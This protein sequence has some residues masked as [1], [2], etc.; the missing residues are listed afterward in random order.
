MPKQTTSFI[1]GKMN[2][3]LDP[4]IIPVGEYLDAENIM[5][6]QSE[7]SDVGSVEALKDNLKLTSGTVA[8]E[9]Y[10]Y[11]IGYC[12]DSENDK[13]YYFVTKFNSQGGSAKPESSDKSAIIQ[14]NFFNNSTTI[15]IESKYLNFDKFFP[16]TGCNV[17]NDYLYFTDNRN[18]PRVFNVNDAGSYSTSSILEDQLSVAKYAPFCAPKLLQ[19][20][21]VLLV[22]GAVGA[23]AIVNGAVNNSANVAVDGNI[24]GTTIAVGMRVTGTGITGTVTVNT[25]TSQSAIVLSTAV[26][27]ADNT[28]LTFA[29]T[30]VTIT[31]ANAALQTEIGNGVKFKVLDGDKISFQDVSHIGTPGQ[32]PP[33]PFETNTQ[34]F[35]DDIA[36]SSLSGTTLTLNK[37]VTISDGT[38][39]TLLCCSMVDNSANDSAIDTE[40]LKEKFVK[41]SYRFKFKDNTYSLMA[42][43]SQTAFIP[44]IDTFTAQLQEDAYEQAEVLTF[45]NSINQLELK[46]D[47]PFENPIITLHIKE[48]EILI[49]ESDTVAVK[50]V[51]SIKVDQT[52]IASMKQTMGT[53]ANLTPVTFGKVGTTKLQAYIHNIFKRRHEMYYVYRS[54][55]PYKVLPENQTTRVFDNVPNKALAQELVSNRIV[56]GNFIEGKE[57]PTNLDFKLTVGN[58]TEDDEFTYGEYKRHTLKQNRTYSV[59]L[60]LADRYG[61][62]SPVLLSKKH[63]SS[64]L[65]KRAELGSEVGKCLKV[66]FNE[67]ITTNLYDTETNPLGWYSYRIVVKQKQQDYYNVYTPGA[68]IYDR[69]TDGD[70]YSYFALFGDNINKIPRDEITEGAANIA[71]NLATS[72]VNLDDI[73]ENGDDALQTG[74]RSVIAIATLDDFLDPEDNAKKADQAA[75][76][77]ETKDYLH[78]QTV[79]NYGKSADNSGS[80]VNNSSIK[81]LAVFETQPFISKLDIFFETSTCGLISDLNNKID[82]GLSGGVAA[83]LKLRDLATGNTDKNDF[84]E[85]VTNGTEILRLRAFDADGVELTVGG[86]DLT[87]AINSVTCNNLIS[88]NDQSDLKNSFTVVDDSGILKLEVSHAQEFLPIPENTYNI[89]FQVTTTDGTATF[90]KTIEVKNVVPTL[91]FSAGNTGNCVSYTANTTGFLTK[92]NVAPRKIEARNGSGDTSHDETNLAGTATSIFHYE[93]VSGDSRVQVDRDGTISLSSGIGASETGLSFVLKVTDIGGD[94]G[95]GNFTATLTVPLCIVAADSINVA[96]STCSTPKF[97]YYDRCYGY[98]QQGGE[99]PGD[100]YKEHFIPST[101]TYCSETGSCNTD[102]EDILSNHVTVDTTQGGTTTTNWRNNQRFKQIFLGGKALVNGAITSGGNSNSSPL[103]VNGL[104]TGLVLSVDMKVA[105]TG[106]PANT[107]ITAVNSQTQVILN[108]AVTVADNATLIFEEKDPIL[109]KVGTSTETFQG[110]HDHDNDPSTPNR[111]ATG[112]LNYF[113]RVAPHD[114]DTPGF[115]GF[116][117]ASDSN[118]IVDIGGVTYEYIIGV[119]AHSGLEADPD[120]AFPGVRKLIR[121]STINGITNTKFTGTVT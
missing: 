87:I 63:S 93:K 94:D 7:T 102:H 41:F 96:N 74:G 57:I 13:V 18:Q 6:G 30:T 23:K 58:K 109:G 22:N 27:L 39:L 19:P 61:R 72:S 47:L 81:G 9:D 88:R 69:P 68:T 48:V 49:K 98:S 71:M 115:A 73:V 2:K 14:F 95:A 83:D 89:E 111:S 52:S 8:T 119:S 21:Y 3:D 51:D 108:N 53:G 76:Y 55:D 15:L 101:L 77:D 120:N 90:E 50:V 85:S 37:P 62:Q 1:K 91:A 24:A 84:N 105:G 114:D 5:V 121:R 118:F 26:T 44:A 17:I 40:F 10:G 20:K 25:V 112:L 46:I 42:P 59:G 54:E 92:V 78:V 29:S 110:P 12:L 86:N 116:K 64:I 56:Y 103:N 106:I 70:G 33:H 65:N 34:T 31:T 107:K 36:V 79:G 16:I 11:V 35:P 117:G 97:N 80:L 113:I 66:I 43:F 99:D 82:E 28:I 60:V 4:R 45:I 100:L 32:D 67:K 104:S 38:K 75:F